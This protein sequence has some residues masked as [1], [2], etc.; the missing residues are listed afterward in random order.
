M[1]S[2]NVLRTFASKPYVVIERDTND[3]IGSSGNKAHASALGASKA[4]ENGYRVIDLGDVDGFN[5]AAV[6]AHD[7]DGS[8]VAQY[9]SGLSCG[10]I[11]CWLRESKNASFLVD[12]TVADRL[13]KTLGKLSRAAARKQVAAWILAG[14]VG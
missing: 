7:I 11:D 14:A 2:K 3:V 10:V 5:E 9:A 13:R 1:T 6:S 12:G 8:I 4:G